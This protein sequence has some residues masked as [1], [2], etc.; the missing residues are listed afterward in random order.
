MR[1]QAAGGLTLDVAEVARF[2]AERDEDASR[3]RWLVI[4]QGLALMAVLALV[5]L[6]VAFQRG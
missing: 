5:A 3:E 4:G 6:M 2:V 1:R